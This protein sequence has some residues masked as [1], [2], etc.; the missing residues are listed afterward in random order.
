MLQALPR[1]TAILAAACSLAAVLLA[2]RPA[3]A[4]VNRDF[5]GIVSEDVFSGN[6]PYRALH[7]DQQ[8]RVG[9]GLTRQP[10]YW[11]SMEREAAPRAY[12][13]SY[14]DEYVGQTAARGIR[15]M[16]VLIDPPAFRSSAPARGR[17]RGVYPPRSFGEMGRW[18]AAL[19]RRYGPKG[20]L[21]SERPALR[22]VPI[23]AWQVWNEPNLP[24]FW[25]SGPSPVQYT[26]M[27]RA[28]SSAIKGVDRGAEIV[29]AGLPNSRLGI[30]FSRFL[31]G[32]YR[33]GAA[34]GFD[35]LAIHPYARTDRGVVAAVAAARRL[36]NAW[37]DRRA[38]I[39]VT[40]MGWATGGP[41]SSFR[42][43]EREQGRLI[44]STLLG[45]A[46]ARRG[47]RLRGAVYFN[48]KD[49]RPTKGNPDFFGYYTGLLRR[50]GRRKLGFEAFRSASAQ[51][52]R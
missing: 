17:K 3:D 9:I 30:P 37:R 43:S 5:V 2:P 32:M 40:E 18:A 45:L 49:S 35:T 36:M 24:V 34:S 16:P 21:W 29:S 26:R 42:V 19:V 38:A 50:D 10:F 20:T 52:R 6:S 23:R 7:L 8:A 47:L 39:W 46:K 44:R 41:R 14:Y 33:A 1:H 12:D 51:L 11:F 13:F 25:A 27:L 4:A 28:V 31:T 48:W 22:K 15:V